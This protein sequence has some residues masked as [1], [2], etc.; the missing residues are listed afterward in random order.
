MSAAHLLDARLYEALADAGLP[1]EAR[2]HVVDLCTAAVAIA[3]DLGLPHPG[4]TARSAVQ[5]L[6]GTELAL[7]PATLGDIAR[8]CEVAVVRA[9]RPTA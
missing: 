7:D 6:V 1:G 8:L 4:R 3:L 5:L 2:E 9:L